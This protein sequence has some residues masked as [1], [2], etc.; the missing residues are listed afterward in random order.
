MMSTLEKGRKQCIFLIP[1][2]YHHSRIYHIGM[3]GLGCWL[4]LKHHNLYLGNHHHHYL[5]LDHDRQQAA[6]NFE[7]NNKNKI[8]NAQ[9]PAKWYGACCDAGF[10]ISL[11][12]LSNGYKY[13]IILVDTKNWFWL[14]SKQR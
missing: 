6:C 13:I 2:C 10:L 14:R 5:Y 4:K 9:Q 7:K 3:P 8:K 11:N 1:Q 12:K